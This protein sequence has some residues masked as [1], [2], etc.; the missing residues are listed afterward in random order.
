MVRE[1]LPVAIDKPPLNGVSPSPK[2]WWGLITRP[3]LIMGGGFNKT[4]DAKTVDAII[5]SR[6]EGTQEPNPQD[7]LQ[8]SC[9]EHTR[10]ANRFEGTQELNPQD[11]PQTAARSTR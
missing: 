6:F 5:R 1:L 3:G 4:V 7:K 8:T 10:N 2:I 9:Q 11:S